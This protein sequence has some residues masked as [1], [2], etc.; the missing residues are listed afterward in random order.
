MLFRSNEQITQVILN[1][2]GLLINL[3]SYVFPELHCLE[4]E[5]QNMRENVVPYVMSLIYTAGV[6]LCIAGYGIYRQFFVKKTM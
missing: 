4:R 2:A 1:K 5:T 3:N 6:A